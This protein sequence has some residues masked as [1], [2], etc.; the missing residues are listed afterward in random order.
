MMTTQRQTA[1]GPVPLAG[2]KMKPVRYAVKGLLPL[3]RLTLLIG[4]PGTTKTLALIDLGAQLSVGD[5]Q[6]DLHYRRVNTLYIT[7]ENSRTESLVPRAEAAGFDLNRF[8]HCGDPLD[9]PDE[10]EKL[11]FWVKK[12]KAKLV[13]LDTIN[14]FARLSLNNSQQHAKKVFQPLLTMA[15]EL[16]CAVVCVIWATKAGKGINAVAGSVGNSGTA[17]NVIVVGQLAA[18]QYVIGT[19]K[20][21]DG[22]DHFGF[23]YHWDLVEVSDDGSEPINVPRITWEKRATPAEIDLA[24][25]QVKL[26]DDPAAL[27]L[28]GYMAEPSADWIENPAPKEEWSD[29]DW[30]LAGWFPTKELTDHIE[31]EALIG[32]TAARKVINHAHAAGLI[33]R[34]RNGQGRDHKV[35]WRI[36]DLGR[37]WMT[38][39]EEDSIHA[40]FHTS[41]RKQPKQ[42]ARRPQPPK[43]LALPRAED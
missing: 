1:P 15:E 12:F 9:L 13:V 37:L 31:E 20:A 42:R 22:P 10:M 21:N 28:L 24:H 7:L 40:Y 39:D 34:S 16:D 25:E 4:K 18:Q 6:G 26:T 11:R 33:E 38:E 36:T 35:R 32:S 2:I 19:I 14:D 8:F 29:N 27:T 3:G 30:K 43:P 23:L 5:V 17:R 41:Q